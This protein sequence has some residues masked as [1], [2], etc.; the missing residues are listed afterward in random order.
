MPD[1]NKS[2]VFRPQTKDLP[3]AILIRFPGILSDLQKWL[4]NCRRSDCVV[5]L[6][7]ET[8]AEIRIDAYKSNL[9][10][11]VTEAGAHPNAN[12]KYVRL[13]RA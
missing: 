8:C 10:M 9:I 5:D 2:S 7:S 4:A 6:Q 3:N 13:T 1:I 11:V 12:N